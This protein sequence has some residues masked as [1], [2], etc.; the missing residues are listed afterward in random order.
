MQVYC[1]LRPRGWTVVAG[2]LDIAMERHHQMLV[3]HL[4]TTRWALGQ[5]HLLIP[6]ASCVCKHPCTVGQRKK[7]GGWTNSHHMALHEGYDERWW[8]WWDRKAPGSDSSGHGTAFE[9]LK[10]SRVIGK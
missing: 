4:G 9:V 2:L 8:L 7:R 1:I 6:D 10:G 5:M 3:L